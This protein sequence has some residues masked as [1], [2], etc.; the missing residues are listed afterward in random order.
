MACNFLALLS[1]YTTETKTNKTMSNNKRLERDPQNKV[2]GGVC[3]GLGNYFDMDPTFWRVLFFILFLFGCS[4][5]LIYIILWIAMPTAIRP[6]GVVDQAV[7]Q[8]SNPDVEKRKRNSSMASG[9][10]LIGIGVVCL[11]A[12]YIPQISWRTVWPI[13]L[14]VLG[15]FLIIPFKTKQS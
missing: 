14:I 12:R 2:I 1:L 6:N 15:I 8:P 3:S 10:T 5:L 7:S 13:I 11:L 9:L 4:G